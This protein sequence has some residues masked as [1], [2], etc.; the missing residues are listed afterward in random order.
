MGVQRNGERCVRL[1]IRVKKERLFLIP[2]NVK[3]SL[4]VSSIVE[5]SKCK[6]IMKINSMVMGIMLKQFIGLWEM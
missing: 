1:C 3:L 2:L 4:F 6:C 5:V